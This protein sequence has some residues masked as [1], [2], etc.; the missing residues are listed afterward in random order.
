MISKNCS[1]GPVSDLDDTFS[2]SLPADTDF[3]KD[4]RDALV[5][6]ILQRILSGMTWAQYATISDRLE[7]LLRDGDAYN[8]WPEP[9]ALEL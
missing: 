2:F 4:R 5:L 7:R 6:N 1:P 8:V 9:T 3:L